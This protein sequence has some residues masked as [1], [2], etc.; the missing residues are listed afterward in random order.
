VED[1]TIGVLC[2]LTRFSQAQD[3]IEWEIFRTAILESQGWRLHRLYTPHFYRD[4]QGCTQG[5]LRD[6]A[7][8]L[9]GEDEKDAIRVVPEEAPR[10]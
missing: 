7:D 5:I 9:A 1:V 8:F 2:D 6:V 4:R 10:K 3:A